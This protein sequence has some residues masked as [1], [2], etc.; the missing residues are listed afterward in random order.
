MRFFRTKGSQH[1]RVS[2]LSR[3]IAGYG[4]RRHPRKAVFRLPWFWGE[5]SDFEFN[6]QRAAIADIC[7]DTISERLQYLEGIGRIAGVFCF[8]VATITQQS[9]IAVAFRGRRPQHLGQ[10]SLA[11]PLPQLH[12]EQTVLRG[13]KA[14]G[15]EEIMLVLR[16]NMGN[17]PAVA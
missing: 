9:S 6:R 7:I 15:K 2:E 3:S 4:K 5:A 11:G 13:H 17:T 10:P 8:H 14:L 1:R 12:L 16:V